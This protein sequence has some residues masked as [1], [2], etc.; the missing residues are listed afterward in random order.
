MVAFSRVLRVRFMGVTV[1]L[2]LL[3]GSSLLM[4]SP[5]SLS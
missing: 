4:L 2:I 3:L 1:R 5:L